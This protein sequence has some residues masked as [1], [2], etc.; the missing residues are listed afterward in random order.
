MYMKKILF[1][2]FIIAICIGLYLYV[3]HIYMY[4]K[5][6]YM[7]LESTQTQTKYLFSN[8]FKKQSTY[9]ALGDSLTAGVGTTQ[10]ESSYPYLF[11]NLFSEKNKTNVT[12]VP[13]AIPG[14][15]TEDARS[16]LLPDVIKTKPDIV[17]IL[18]GV[19][20]I[21]GRIDPEIFEKNYRDIITQLQEK[22]SADIYIINIPYIGHSTLILPPYNFYFDIKT[23]E[24]NEILKQISSEYN[25]EYIDLYT[26]TYPQKDK[27]E[28]YARDLFH[29]SDIGYTLWAQ[30]IYEYFSK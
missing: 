13:L 20:D 27:K 29:P 28:Y 10:Y 18:L 17:T 6:G 2:F 8:N 26:H 9:V 5:I 25:I 11:S 3:A 14:A 15:K 1:V 12:L 19:N 7:R 16:L 30:Y 4:K 22:T 24:Y 21:H 23:K